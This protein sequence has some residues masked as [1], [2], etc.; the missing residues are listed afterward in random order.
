M[1]PD[2]DRFAQF[3]IVEVKTDGA[4]KVRAYDIIT[5]RFFPC[6]KV[7]RPPFTPENFIYTE[8]KRASAVRPRFPAHTPITCEMEGDTAKIT[9]GQ[10]TCGEERVK[11]YLVRV[12]RKTDGRILRCAAAWSGYYL[13][14]MPACVTVRIRDLPPGD[15]T[16]AVTARSFW[17]KESENT[18][19]LDFSVM[20]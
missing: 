1:P 15:Y 11:D 5:G 18:L 7:I 9:F 6:D 16:A 8:E 12:T 4:V 3:L 19:R 17:G 20:E 14:D 10:A 13:Y 2:G